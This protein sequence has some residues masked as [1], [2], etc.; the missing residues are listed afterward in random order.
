MGSSPTTPTFYSRALRVLAPQWR[1]SSTIFDTIYKGSHNRF[2]IEKVRFVR[3]D[4]AVVF[5]PKAQAHQF[6]PQ[7]NPCVE[8]TPGDLNAEPT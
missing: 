2:Q 8:K 4:V 6:C 3:P 1:R 5:I 7:L